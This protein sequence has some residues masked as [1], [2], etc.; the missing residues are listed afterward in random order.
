MAE[1]KVGKMK[2]GVTAT[3]PAT[4]DAA[5]YAALTFTYPDECRVT[6]IGEVNHFWE[7]A[8][9]SPV[10]CD[11]VGSIVKPYKTN[12][13]VSNF[14]I[15]IKFKKDDPMIALI[16]ANKNSASSSLYCELMEEGG[17]NKVY[18]SLQFIKAAQTHGSSEDVVLLDCEAFHDHIPVRN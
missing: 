14:T 5:G 15:V 1:S 11:V 12:E 10:I 6:Q 13:K 18:M 3:A 8:E 16:E 9:E 17:V 7:T 4:L 2:F